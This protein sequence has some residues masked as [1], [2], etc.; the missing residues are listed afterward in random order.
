MSK[1]KNL[2]ELINAYESL[3]NRVANVSE[4][5][6]F[7]VDNNLGS[8]TIGGGDLNHNK[9]SHDSL[10]YRKSKIHERITDITSRVKN[11]VNQCL[12]ELSRK[13]EKEGYDFSED[14]SVNGFDGNENKKRRYREHLLNRYNSMLSIKREL[15]EC[16]TIDQ[17]KLS[18]VSISYHTYLD[19]KP[20]Y[21]ERPFAQKLCSWLS[22]GVT[23]FYRSF[24]AKE[25]SL[26]NKLDSY[27]ETPSIGR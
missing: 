18:T 26:Q 9:K 8:L 11:T 10:V 7:I 5:I 17:E 21:K 1:V 6:R 15:A 22:V 2:R 4:T 19:N 20:S 14:G 3:Q 25:I 12:I 24:F 23:I 13:M 16:S 27:L